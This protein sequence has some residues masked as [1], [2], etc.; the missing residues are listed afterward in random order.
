MSSD[1]PPRDAVQTFPVFASLQE[2]YG[3]L[4]GNLGLFFRLAAVPFVISV[5]ISLFAVPFQQNIWILLPLSLLA[6]IPH[7]IFA[8]AWH[9]RTLLGPEATLASQPVSWQPRHWRF[10]GYT[11]LAFILIPGVIVAIGILASTLLNNLSAALGLTIL[12]LSGLAAV[13]VEVR[14]SF[15]LP[16]AAVEE[17]YGL[18]DSW[19]HTRQQ[20]WR[21][22]AAYLLVLI[23]FIFAVLLFGLVL[24][25][26]AGIIGLAVYGTEAEMA[27]STFG[28]V[29]GVLINMLLTYP[30]AAMMISILSIAFRDCTGWIP[31]DQ[32]AERFS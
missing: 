15:A 13:Y 30:I 23:P 28:N 2:A 1:Q 24:G 22:L 5:A 8:V 11:A 7:T 4:F 31:H 20:V 32:I 10:L 21:I 12:A 27:A 6:Y 25:A 9:R 19:R 29:A 3:T 16:A 17:K 18:G 14:L 26:I